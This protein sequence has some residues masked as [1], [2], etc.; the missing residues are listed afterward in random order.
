[1]NGTALAPLGSVGTTNRASRPSLS[2]PRTPP[3]PAPRPSAVVPIAKKQEPPALSEAA[4]VE[5]L[6]KLSRPARDALL[7]RVDEQVGVFERVTKPA[8]E[9]VVERKSEPAPALVA[10]PAPVIEARA[11]LNSVDMEEVPEAQ[12]VTKSA[13][14]PLPP[15]ASA[16]PPPPPPADIVLDLVRRAPPVAIKE[17]AAVVNVA[18]R[19]PQ[20]SITDVLFDA[21]HELSFF[22]SAVEGGSFCLA[23]A[24]RALPCLAGLVH[25]YDVENREFVVVYA[26]GPRAE[27]LLGTR[28]S[29]SDR[30]LSRAAMQNVATVEDYG[31]AGAPAPVSRHAFFGDPWSVLCVPVSRRGRMLGAIELVD[32][33]SGGGFDEKAK[34][35]LAY[36]AERYAE[37]LSERGITLPKL[38]P[39][40]DDAAAQ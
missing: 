23:T 5:F 6:V 18:P 27:R 35:A 10:A 14:P 13:P 3:R 16:P 22:E 37:F 9:P 21:M 29:G 39:P 24:L 15:R 40:P 32:P 31:D 11:T 38:A 4:V 1:M 36:V 25:L 30:L 20:P 12:P 34:N 8:P 17:P 2:S 33:T 19:A 26:Q 7:A 28:Q